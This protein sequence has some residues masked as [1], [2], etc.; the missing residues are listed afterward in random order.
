MDAALWDLIM[1]KSAIILAGGSSR[2]FSGDKG[3]LELDGKSL[4]RHV[5]GMTHYGTGPAPVFFGSRFVGLNAWWSVGLLISVVN[6]IIW[7]GIG[8]PWW[9]FLGIM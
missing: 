1:D 5:V 2:G 7:L 3:C 9:S 6:L 4:L 8:W